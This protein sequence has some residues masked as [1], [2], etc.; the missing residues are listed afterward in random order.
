MS[1]VPNTFHALRVSLF[2]CTRF[3]CELVE[4]IDPPDDNYTT[5]FKIKIADSQ[6]EFVCA[7]DDTILRAALR[8]GLGMPYEC[9]VGSCGTCKTE[10]VSGEVVSNWPEAPALTDRDRTRNRVLGCQSRPTADCTIK[11]R[12]FD[13]YR[14]GCLPQQSKATLAKCRDLTHDIREFQFELDTP[15]AF[16]P[17]QYALLYAPGITGPRAYSM[18]NIA[19]GDG[20]WHFQIKRVPGGSGSNAL[21]DQVRVGDTLTVDGPY[22]LAYLRTDSPRDIVCIAG[23]SGLAPMISI[24]RGVAANPSMASRKVHFFYGGRGQRDICGEDMLCDL[25]GFGQHIFFHPIISMPAQD[26]GQEWAGKIGFVHELVLEVLG[27]SLPEHEIYFAG[28]PAMAQAV[29]RM[30]VEEKVPGTQVHYDAFY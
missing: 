16:L 18:S 25:P 30:L 28:P 22:G 7:P 27:K 10:L 17:G 26:D 3:E 5:M 6:Q 8:A 4:Q 2:S 29:Q 20:S 24:A 1:L 19:Q 11:A 9:N 15:I 23:G 12:L 13:Q 21:F 14:T